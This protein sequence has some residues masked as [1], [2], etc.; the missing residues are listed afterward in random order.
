MERN[1]R[2]KQVATFLYL[3]ICFNFAHVHARYKF[4]A[5]TESDLMKASLLKIWDWWFVCEKYREREKHRSFCVSQNWY[6]SAPLQDKQL[7]SVMLGEML[8]LMSCLAVISH[9]LGA[10][11]S[12]LTE[13]CT[14]VSGI[15]M[16]WSHFCC[17]GS[18]PFVKGC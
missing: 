1:K 3:N 2:Q 4:N 9:S 8:S 6:L 12:F 5:Y 18:N 10:C 13:I 17:W 15:W 7:S 16:L 14:A 11:I